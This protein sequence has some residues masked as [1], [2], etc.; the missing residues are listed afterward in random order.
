[1]GLGKTLQTIGL[2]LLSPPNGNAY[3]EGTNDDEPQKMSAEE[4]NQSEEGKDNTPIPADSMIRS[5]KAAI[6]KS[7][8]KAAGLKLSG[9][10]SDQIDRILAGI[11]DGK[12]TGSHFP[13]FMTAPPPPT[14]STS[15]SFGSCTL[16][17]CPVSVMS[18]WEVQIDS[19]VK[20]GVLNVRSYHGQDRHE[21]LPLLQSGKIDVLIVSYSTLSSEFKNA[22]PELDKVKMDGPPTKRTKQS[23]LFDV[24]F[25]RIILDEAVS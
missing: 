16:I 18:N 13:A 20:R 12:I 4:I 9:K 23:T 17:V 25:H 10:K 2:I 3:P 21:L 11:K 7:I 15:S 19:F 5:Q 22:Y 6:L 1:M 24:S 8:L 14:S